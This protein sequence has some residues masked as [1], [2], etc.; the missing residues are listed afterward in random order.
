MIVERVFR[1]EKS[2][3]NY[4][5]NKWMINQLKKK[6]SPDTYTAKVHLESRELR[7]YKR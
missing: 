5:Q 6:Y 2:M 3:Q 1:S 4:M 7:V